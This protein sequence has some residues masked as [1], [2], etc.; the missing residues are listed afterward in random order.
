ME[1]QEVLLEI[2]RKAIRPEYVLSDIEGIKGE[3]WESVMRLAQEHAILPMVYETVW[4]EE[5]FRRIP[6]QMQREY[7][8]RVQYQ[9]IEQ[10]QNTST[11]LKLYQGMLNIDVTPLVVKGIICRN[12]YRLP[13]Y[14]NSGDEDILIKREEFSKLDLFLQQ[15]GF[16]RQWFEGDIQTAHEIAYYNPRNRMRLEIHLSLFPEESGSYGRLNREFP[17][18]F[19]RHIT[20]KIQGVEIHTLDETQHM[21]YLLCHGLK[22]FLHSGFGVRQLCDMILFAEKHGEVIDWNEI[23]RRTKRQKMYVFWMNLFDIGE[24]YLGFS[25]DKAHLR[26]PGKAML[27]SRGLLDDIMDSGV[28]GKRSEERLHSANITLEASNQS[29]QRRLG[30]VAALFPSAEYMRRQYPYLLRK[31]WLLPAAWVQRMIAYKKEMRGRG[32][33]GA[34]EAGRQRVKLLKKYGIIEKR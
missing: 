9:V 25:W 11:F 18:V 15:Q 31:K 14:R 29:G 21:L 34:V 17:Q 23:R 10:V 4:N 1:I 16:V 28:F 32:M 30:V 26:R 3:D 20:Q 5:S 6:V 2:L 22:H 33:A 7:K 24:R 8:T 13:D 19:E 27:D 12:M